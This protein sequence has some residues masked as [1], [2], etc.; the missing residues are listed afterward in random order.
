MNRED[1]KWATRAR[2][3]VR[4]KADLRKGVAFAEVCAAAYLK[5]W[6]DQGRIMKAIDAITRKLSHDGPTGPQGQ[7]RL[8]LAAHGDAQG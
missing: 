2:V 8:S 5:R 7:R 1:S 6:N 3:Y 4:L